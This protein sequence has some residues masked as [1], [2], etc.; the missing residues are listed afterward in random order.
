MLYG[1]LNEFSS[2]LDEVKQ[3][4]SPATLFSRITELENMFEEKDRGARQKE[5]DLESLSLLVQNLR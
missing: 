2:F 5:L 3:P 4:R 1:F